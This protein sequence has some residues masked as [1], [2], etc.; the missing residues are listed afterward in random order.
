ME[1]T[2]ELNLLTKFEEMMDYAHKMI[3]QFPKHQRHTSAARIELVMLDAMEL[4]I[5]A[6]LKYHKKT[7]LRDLDIKLHLLRRL[8]RRCHAWGYVS[9]KAYEVWSRH[10]QE[11]GRILGGWIKWN[12]ENQA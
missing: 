5:E 3:N 9:H 6:N 4:I 12:R 11:I 10:L 1:K 7:T 8:V 2:Q